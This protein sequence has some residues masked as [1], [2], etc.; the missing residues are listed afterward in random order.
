MPGKRCRHE[1]IV[2]RVAYSTESTPDTASLPIADILLTRRL[3]T[4][5]HIPA[6]ERRNALR[7]AA[8]CS[9]IAHSHR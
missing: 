9:T 3:I 2:A 4:V 8:L 7:I 1:G 6:P 5:G